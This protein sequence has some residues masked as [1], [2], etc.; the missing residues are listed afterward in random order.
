MLIEHSIF[1]HVACYI[2]N[3]EYF[4]PC[5]ML[6]R[7]LFNLCQPNNE[8]CN[9]IANNIITKLSQVFSFAFII[10]NL[11]LC[12]R[13]N[14]ITSRLLSSVSTSSELYGSLLWKGPKM[15]NSINVQYKFVQMLC[16]QYE[17]YC[18]E[19]LLKRK[20]ISLDTLFNKTYI[21]EYVYSISIY[22]CILNKMRMER[23]EQKRSIQI[24]WCHFSK[25]YANNWLNFF[26]DVNKLGLETK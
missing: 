3:I 12:I 26:A 11:F 13:H 7:N 1:V 23:N 25:Y 4:D 21:I 20:F 19:L 16:V 18:E 14:W 17:H 9:S 5:V 15:K 6:T 2:I 22:L 8:L 10:W 24:N